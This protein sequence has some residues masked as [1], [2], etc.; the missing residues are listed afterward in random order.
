M[1][2]FIGSGH[3]QTYEQVTVPVAL[4]N[5]SKNVAAYNMQLD[6]NPADVEVIAVTPNYGT[7][8][9]QCYNSD[10][11]CFDSRYSNNE[12]WIRAMWVDESG[13]NN[14]ISADTQLFEVTLKVK[15]G[16][17]S[18]PLTIDSTKAANL[19]FT[20]DEI[21]PISVAVKNEEPSVNKGLYMES[22]AVQAGQTITVPLLLESDI[23]P[24]ALQF[25]VQSSSALAF[26][27]VQNS[28][29]NN[30]LTI[31]SHM[32]SNGITRVLVGSSSNKEI[33]NGEVAILQFEVDD[34]L[35]S[36]EILQATLNK[37]K[38]ADK[39]GLEKNYSEQSATFTIKKNTNANLSQLSLSGV[40]F[41]EKFSPNT[42]T[43]SSKLLTPPN[44]PIEIT[45]IKADNKATISYKL[46]D[47][48]A[49]EAI[50]PVP[51]KNK[52]DIIVTAEDGT[53]TTYTVNL[54]VGLKGDADVNGKI[55]LND[56]V[57]MSHFIVGKKT[58]S[59]Q[60]KWNSDLN[61]DGEISLGDWVSLAN[62]LLEQ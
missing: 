10:S 25:D 48:S 3:V 23:K 38:M 18:Q 30:E 40:V 29:I 26:K 32:Q 43:Y 58:P 19:L 37:I 7:S 42:L 5:V 24:V 57:A 2:V 34:N 15:N 39:S 49:S 20:D 60:A 53:K 31:E 51:G 36:D 13:G 28:I 35:S 14:L 22:Q 62:R 59:V 61:D 44:E 1:E 52:I 4:H 21:N 11:S 54:I 12:G 6:F 17:V 50:I 27:G 47:T 55:D 8:G 16:H 9:S 33:E 41:N 56:W 45:A 46:N